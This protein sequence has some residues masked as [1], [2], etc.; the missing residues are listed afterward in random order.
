MLK[1]ATLA[2]TSYTF[3]PPSYTYILIAPRS[4][5]IVAR[6]KPAFSIPN[7]LYYNKLSG[8]VLDSP[9]LLVT[10]VTNNNRGY[11]SRTQGIF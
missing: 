6:G 8:L 7:K 4:K 9:R 2:P 10:I 1:I 11:R 3:V 5:S